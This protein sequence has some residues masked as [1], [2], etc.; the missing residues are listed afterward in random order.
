MLHDASKI[1]ASVNQVGIEVATVE[2]GIGPA[3]VKVGIEVAEPLVARFVH[4][5]LAVESESGQAAVVKPK[6][7]TVRMR[8]DH[9]SRAFAILHETRPGSR[10][11]S[12][13]RKARELIS[14]G[15][16][17]LSGTL[18]PDQQNQT[19]PT[20]YSATKLVEKRRRY[21]S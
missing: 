8:A 16:M 13:G 17:Q 2:A 4:F 21:G 15:L 14:I 9:W 3:V 1:D 6:A 20:D 12:A 18:T 10:G 19:V 11:L 5:A 7:V